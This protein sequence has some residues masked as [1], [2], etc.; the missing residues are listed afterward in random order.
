MKHLVDS[1]NSIGYS[2]LRLR[3]IQLTAQQTKSVG[4]TLVVPPWVNFKIL[5]AHIKTMSVNQLVN[6]IY[7]PQSSKKH[8]TLMVI[9]PL[10]TDVE[11]VY[12]AD[13]G[14]D[15]CTGTPT[16]STCISESAEVLFS[17]E[18]CWSCTSVCEGRLA[19]G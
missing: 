9:L 8:Q 7:S 6:D 3:H 10:L 14:E 11:S 19:A 5:Y 2:L 15:S 17:A 4:N 12:S 18:D 1:P 16:V 13:I